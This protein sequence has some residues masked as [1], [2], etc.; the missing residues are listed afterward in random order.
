MLYDNKRLISNIVNYFI[1]LNFAFLPSDPISNRWKRHLLICRGSTIGLGVKF[2]RNLWIDQYSKLIIGNNVF[3]NY[4]CMIV[5]GGGV[6]IGDNVLLGPGVTIL[7]ANHDTNPGVLMRTSG[8]VFGHVNIGP[9][10]WLA[11]RCTILP[12]VTIGEGAVVAAGAVVTKDVEPHTIV[13]GVPASVI[14]HR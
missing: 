9:D 8:P 12:G 3:F 14:R 5:S 1:E 2:G 11:A 4:G 13:G 10:V 6:S 7:S